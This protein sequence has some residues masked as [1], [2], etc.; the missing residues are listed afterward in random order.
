MHA[1]FERQDVSIDPRTDTKNQPPFAPYEVGQTT[2]KLNC[3]VGCLGDSFG[4][5]EFSE[6]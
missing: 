2:M 3:N 1:P 5:L 6:E 4:L